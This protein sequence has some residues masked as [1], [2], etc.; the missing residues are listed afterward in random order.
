[1]H[2]AASA[3]PCNPVID[4]TYC[5]TQGPRARH[6]DAP[7]RGP[8]LRPIEGLGS[9]LMN[10]NEQPATLGGITLRGGASNCISFMRRSSCN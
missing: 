1:M 3:Q 5:A 9:D 4:G 6:A 7:A 10:R 2:T 8:N